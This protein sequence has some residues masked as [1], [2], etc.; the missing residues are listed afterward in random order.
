MEHFPL[1]LKLTG[2]RI[3]LIGN[4]ADIIPKA[5]LLAKTSAQIDIFA[6]VPCAE[7]K[8]FMVEAGLADPHAGHKSHLLI[9]HERQFAPA[10]LADPSRP[11]LAFA[12]LDT[13]SPHLV[14]LFEATHL[15]YCVIDDLARSQFTTPA[16]IDRSP[17]TIAIGTE[18]TA[19]VLARRLK[20][21]IEDRLAVSLA[22]VAAEAGRL[23]GRVASA[24]DRSWL[25]CRRYSGGC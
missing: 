7:L 11:K 15:P 24:F 1:Y 3:A 5:R 20:A 10:D 19:P 9:H 13:P 14:T 16:L 18:G 22:Q 12:Y 2:R 6:E 4:S 21:A 23:R 8:A 25:W 17:V